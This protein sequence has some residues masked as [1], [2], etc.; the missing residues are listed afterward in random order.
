MD[1]QRLEK[2]WAHDIA[3]SID[4]EKSKCSSFCSSYLRNG[5]LPY[6]E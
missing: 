6:A 5:W 3:F 2:V 1:L 4:K